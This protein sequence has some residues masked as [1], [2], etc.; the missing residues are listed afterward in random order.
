MSVGE[1]LPGDMVH[2]VAALQQ[3]GIAGD[4]LK[5]IT[6]GLEEL[7][8]GGG[9]LPPSQNLPHL[10]GP[11]PLRYTAAL[12]AL[13]QQLDNI[14]CAMLFTLSGS[15]AVDPSLP[16]WRLPLGGVCG[17]LHEVPVVLLFGEFV[18]SVIFH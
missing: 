15:F 4:T 13:P 11:S 1:M 7:A 6:T 16:C 17:S 8:E 3:G 2:V 9:S 5:D 10:V 14:L 18:S 12:Q